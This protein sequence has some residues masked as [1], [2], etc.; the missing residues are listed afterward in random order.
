M[1]RLN[2]KERKSEKS[3]KK[4]ENQENNSG[5]KELLKTLDPVMKYA[6]FK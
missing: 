5:L 3:G 4:S 2:K 1:M 6:I